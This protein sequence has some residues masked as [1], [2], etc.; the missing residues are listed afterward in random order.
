LARVCSR[1]SVM[2]ASVRAHARE[3]QVSRARAENPDAAGGTSGLTDPLLDRE[4]T[5]RP[6][7][8]GFNHAFS[9]STS[10]PRPNMV[11]CVTP[12][13]PGNLRQHSSAIGKLSHPFAS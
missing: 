4:A 5:A 8:I 12:A 6:Q 9:L 7:P 13:D 2:A 11:V 10:S 1:I 3:Q